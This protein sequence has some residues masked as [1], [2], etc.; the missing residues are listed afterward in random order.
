[1]GTDIDYAPDLLYEINYIHAEEETTALLCG[2]YEHY[3]G[4]IYWEIFIRREE[5]SKDCLHF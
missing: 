1:M 3:I 2:K 4:E 5:M